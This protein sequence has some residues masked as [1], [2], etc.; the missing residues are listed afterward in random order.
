MKENPPTPGSRR[1]GLFLTALALVASARLQPDAAAATA[2]AVSNTGQPTVTAA[3]PSTT[4]VAGQFTTGSSASGTV[5]L[6]SVVLRAWNQF[7]G[8]GFALQLYGDTGGFPGSPIATLAGAAP[9]GNAEADFTYTAA[10]GVFL[11]DTTPYWLVASATTTAPYSWA[12]TDS[13]SETGLPGWSIADR[14][15]YSSNDGGN[16]TTV[17]NRSLKFAV[18]IVV[19]EPSTYAAGVMLAGAV[20]G[21]WWRRRAR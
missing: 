17:D 5:E 19:P 12:Q 10:P 4:L 8:T 3:G 7:G 13:A 18:N 20:G 21:L 16:W 2:E 14:W 15:R 9:S 11:S 6:A 1:S